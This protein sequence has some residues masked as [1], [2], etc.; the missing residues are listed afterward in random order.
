MKRKV[1][2]GSVILLV[3]LI[4]ATVVSYAIGLFWIIG[5]GPKKRLNRVD[6]SVLSDPGIHMIMV[7]TGTPN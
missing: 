5:S 2:F 7:G 3:V 4:V 6:R 1:I